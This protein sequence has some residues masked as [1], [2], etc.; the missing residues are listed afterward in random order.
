[1]QHKAF[2]TPWLGANAFSFPLG[3]LK[4]LFLF[5]RSQL[6]NSLTLHFNTTNTY[7]GIDFTK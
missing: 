7:Y 1:M 5:F 3:N 2:N 4:D 6:T